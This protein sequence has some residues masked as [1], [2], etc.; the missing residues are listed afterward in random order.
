MLTLAMPVIAVALA[1]IALAAAAVPA[2]RAA[3]FGVN[4]FQDDAFY[5]IVTAKHFVE[6]GVF[7]FDGATITNGFQ[8]LWMAIVVVLLE[9]CG[10]PASQ[11]NIVFAIVAAEK[12]CLAGAVA[13]SVAFFVRSWR[14]DTPW[15]AGFLGITLVLLCPLYVVFEQGMETTLAA[16]AFVLVIQ[17]LVTRRPIPLGVAIAFLFLCRLDSGVFIGAPIVVW[18]LLQHS[19]PLRTKAFAMLP[20]A[21]AIGSE[22]A[23]NLAATGHAMPI[24]GA[25]KSSFPLVTWHGGYLVEPFVVMN[26]YGLHTLAYT[27]NIVVVGS[28][29]IVGFLVLPFARMASEDRE[30]CVLMGIVALLL[31]ANLLL[32]QKW[33]KSLDPRY[34]ALPMLAAAFFTA[35][36]LDAAARRFARQLVPVIALAVLAVEAGTWLARAPATWEAKGDAV[37]HLLREVRAALPRDAVL[38]GTDVGALAFWTGRPVFNLDG[39]ISNYALQD[40]IRDGKL[41]DYLRSRGVTHIATALWDREQ[42]YTARPP[43]PMYR[44]QVDAAAQ[45]GEPY[46]CHLYYVYSYVYYVYSDRICLRSANEVFRRNLGLDGVAQT[47]YVVYRLGR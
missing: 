29:A 45:R 42:D 44:H 20:F 46:A 41:G 4:R 21:V 12:I 3:W 26:L 24:S 37:T 34:L 17:A 28:I 2:L 47:S 19:W 5:Y 43:E 23:V 40:V 30:V 32:F 33:E 6:T 14:V 39:V 1:C 13:C 31:L 11:E 10:A 16:L 22:M 18:I 35:T 8:P 36:A 7:T 25:I 27:L 38:A 15:R 9:V